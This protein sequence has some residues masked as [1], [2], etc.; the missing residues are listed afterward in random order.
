MIFLC[1]LPSSAVPPRT[2]AEC[3]ATFQVL[4]AAL[5][6]ILCYFILVIGQRENCKKHYREVS[7]E[8]YVPY[9]CVL[10]LLKTVKYITS[11]KRG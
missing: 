2:D 5:Q 1:C 10:V 9:Y 7:I 4:H 3:M 8:V 6:I 11:V